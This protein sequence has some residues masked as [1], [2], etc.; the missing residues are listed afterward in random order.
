MSVESLSKL[1]EV[2]RAATGFVAL[3]DAVNNLKKIDNAE[4]DSVMPNLSIFMLFLI[5]LQIAKTD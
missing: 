1:P 4:L 5:Y 3:N 2:F